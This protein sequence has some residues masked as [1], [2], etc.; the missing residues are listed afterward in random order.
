[1]KRILLLALVCCAALSLSAQ[2]AFEFT[3]AN[4]TVSLDLA[5]FRSELKRA[6]LEF[7]QRKSNTVV[8]LPLPTGDFA[9][10]SV[11]SSPLVDREELGSYIVTGPWGSGRIA[12][13]PKGISGVMRGP[14]GYFVIEP[15]EDNPGVYRVRNYADFM[16]AVAEVQGPLAC[17]FDDNN[18]PDYG[19]LNID[20]AYD[21]MG[22]DA[23]AGF[24]TKAGNEARELRVYDL[25]MTNTGEF[26]RKF[27]PSADEDDVLAAFNE[28]VS[29]VNGIFEPEIGIRMNLIVVPALIFLD[30]ESD[31]Y[32]NSNQGTELLGQVAPAFNTAGVLAEQYD[33]GHIFTAGCSDVGGVVS[34]QACT[35][36]KTRGVTCVAGSV[37]GAALRIMA[38][39]IAHQ[40]AVSHSWNTCPGSE[41]QRA[42]QTAF[43]PGSGTTIMSYAGACGNQNIGGEESYYHVGSLQQFLRFTR[44]GGAEACATVV[45]TDNFTPEVDFDYED[46]FYIP[47]STPFRLEG[48]ASDANDD[49][50]T[51]NW[52]QFDLGPS[53]NIQE[54]MGNAPLFRSVRPTSTGNVRYFPNL[55]RIVNDVQNSNEVLPT[56]SRDMTFRLTARDNNSQAGGVD[57]QELHFFAEETAGPFLVNNPADDEWN[58]GDYQEVTWDVANT[59][60]APVNCKRVNILMSTN[61]GATFD[62]VL[63]EN[64]VNNGSAFIT[65][66]ESALSGSA[67]LMIEAADNVFLNVNRNIFQVRAAEQA[68]FTLDADLRYDEVCLPEMVSVELNSGSVLG[69]DN[70]ISLS[71]DPETLPAGAVVNLSETAI[72]PGGSSTLDLDLRGV[73]FT[74]R[75]DVTVVAVA[76]D[77]D[78]ARRVITLDLVDND[79]SDLAT[80]APLEGTSGIILSTDFEWTDA[81]NA[82]SYDIQIAT[83]P[84]FAPE[85]IFE[86]ASELTG[87][88]FTPADGFFEPNTLYFWRVRPTNSCGPGSWLDPNSF[89]TVNSQCE[90]FTKGESVTLPGTGPSFTRESTLFI[91]T[92]G[93]INDINIP[94]VNVRYNF[95]SNVSITLVSPAGT[96]VL[97]YGASCFGSTNRVDLGFDD[98]AP[99]GVACPPDDQRVFIPAEP[100]SAFNGED[101]FGEWILRVGVSE[102]GGSAGSIEGWQIQF[103]ADVSAVAP[104]RQVNDA[105]EVPPLMKN[106]IVR[107]KLRVTSSVYGSDEVNYTLTALPEAGR[108]LLYGVELGVG[109]E[110]QQDDINGIGLFYENTNGEATTD[111]FG[112]VV[113][114]PDGGY[115]ATDYHS[116]IIS[117]DAVVSNGNVSLLEDNLTVY[118]NPT[119]GDLNVR[120]TA[121]LNRDLNLEIYDLNG[122]R[123]AQQ[124]VNGRAQNTTVST[125]TLPA[126]VYLL[127]IDGAVRRVVKR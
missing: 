38:H 110:F 15:I 29:A 105:T 123:L 117:D 40:F 44:E 30:P 69:F 47:I 113:T 101:T 22:A 126:G 86:E 41:G 42:G 60:Q 89:R 28:A 68:V 112:Y 94:N 26:A 5:Q 114:T 64:V 32:F 21:D 99:V 107:E 25:V 109:D 14:S 88:T 70:M 20:P 53:S 62:V 84:T 43:E 76:E 66:P 1:M 121:T 36:G 24:S 67:I 77:Q 75:V 91:E 80:L 35:N 39:E 52:E 96:E 8:S 115:L 97:L 7:T 23:G 33:L 65:V 61:A 78:T 92:Q 56:Y 31:P 85:T 106:S 57:W 83:S 51:F 9:D 6:P 3:D 50:L 103:C 90:T 59:D 108:L 63:A 73:N 119:A 102:T 116:I 82:D 11:F 46:G 98:D 48:D 93:T 54:P 18:M 71:V 127:R 37:L 104:E 87:T 72:A 81:L 19:D 95:A 100:L 27:G 118:P 10:Y 49:N 13:S 4:A 125:A 34:G 55:A 111:D 12:T 124:T 120:W 74:G 58:V 16:A 2:S 17:G 45:E 79:Y 122:R